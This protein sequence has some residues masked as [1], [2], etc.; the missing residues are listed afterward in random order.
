MPIG[1]VTEKARRQAAGAMNAKAAMMPDIMPQEWRFADDGRIPNNPLPLLVY[2]QALDLAGESDPAAAFETRFHANG[3]GRDW[4]NGIYDYVHYHAMIHEVLGVARG[5]ARV[6]FG[7]DNG[8]VLDL[9]AG[10]VA[11]LPA[12]TGHQRLAASDDFLAVG[13]Y[14]PTGEYDECRGGA[15]DHARALRTIRQVALPDTDPLYGARGPMRN[16][17]GA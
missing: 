13:A 6:R 16:L 12:G 4:R 14:P 3:W 17:W 8:T 2:V 11:V 1:N 15:E 5:H 7:G 9:R 10:D